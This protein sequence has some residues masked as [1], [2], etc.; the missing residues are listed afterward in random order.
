MPQKKNPWNLEHI[1]SLHKVVIRS[2]L[3]LDLDLVSE[4]QRDL[5]NSASG[6]FA[7]DV[8]LASHALMD[9]MVQVL[10]KLQV[11]TRSLEQHLK[12]A[13]S[14]VFAEAYYILGTQ[15]GIP[16]AHNVVREASREAESKGLKLGDV[17]RSQSWLKDSDDEIHER[18]MQGPRRKLEF[19]K[20]RFSEGHS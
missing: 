19:L 11:H 12:A 10:A 13:G 18:L 2:R 16:M 17:L 6:R 15:A 4:H 5:T 20:Q 14:S 3:A 9:R 1:C 8:F 7:M